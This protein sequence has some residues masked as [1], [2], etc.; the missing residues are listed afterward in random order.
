MSIPV[1]QS[2]ALAGVRHAFFTRQ[3]GVSEGV[4]AS[5][6]GGV[7]SSDVRE[8]VL[9]N[10]ARMA[11]AL[12]VGADRLLVPFQIHSPDCLI[13]DAPWSER[14]RCD[15]LATATPGLALGVTGADCG[16]IL[17]ADARAGVIGAAHAGW[18]GALTGVVE[19]TVAAME[20]LGAR[21][22]D[23]SVALGPTIGATSY[24]VGPEFFER[25]V[26]EAKDH[27]RFFSPSKRDGHKM[28]DLPA[29][30]GFRAERAGAAAF[31][32]LGLDTYGDEKRFYSYRRTTHRK[33]PDYGRL[34][35]A[36]VLG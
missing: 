26:A 23:V 28:F 11:A 12:G 3:G 1:L 35:S 29:F 18:K 8:R 21:R 20:K 31:E 10:R 16:M 36:I 2:K 33:E 4:Y 19:A 13:V 5:L 30:I 32:N 27:A 14:P 22:A 25:F 15:A 24:E 6:N 7:G 34:V 17:F 9:E